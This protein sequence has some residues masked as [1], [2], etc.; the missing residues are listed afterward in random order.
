M[1]L[2]VAVVTDSTSEK[3]IFPSWR[4]Y[5]GELFGYNN[6]F[7]V[8]YSGMAPLFHQVELGG[9]IE[10]PVGYE[11]QLRRKVISRFVASL[12][13]CYDVVIRV[14]V[15]EFLVVDPRNFSSLRAY[16]EE[17]P[18]AY[19]TARGFDVIQLDDEPALSEAS[20]GTLLQNRN[21]A[22]PNTAL[23]KTCIVKTPVDW[24]AGF[25][26]ADVFPSFGPVFMLH[27]KRIDIDW[28]MAWLSGMADTIKDNPNVSDEIRQYYTADREKILRYHS[29]VGRRPKLSGIESWYRDNLLTGYLE[30]IEYSKADG[31]YYGEYGHEQVLCELLPDWKTLL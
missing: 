21:F 24:S 1:G 31:I 13:P 23:N 11:D 18:H 2:R 17:M 27:M 9:L 26:W 6:L 25:H 19:V 7:V 22:Y 16:V 20:I 5:Y 29:D 28:Q 10:L 12:L 15:D 8:T 30:K 4:R 14:D 3:F